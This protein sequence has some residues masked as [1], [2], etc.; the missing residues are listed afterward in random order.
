LNLLLDTHAMLWAVAEPET[1]S[2][3]ARESITSGENTVRFSVGSIWEI[4]IKSA[5]GRLEV[6]GDLVGQLRARRYA[7]LD[8]TTE[9]ALAAGFLPRHHGDP[10][11]RM[12]I[13]QAQLE[14]LTIVTRDPRFALYEVE[15]LAA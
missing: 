9:H 14:K 3:S 1:L 6:P 10:F 4:A 13:A 7:S 12:L 15:V 5:A 2:D 11:D 8:I